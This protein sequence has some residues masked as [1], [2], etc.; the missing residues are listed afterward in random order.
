ME[1]NFRFSGFNWFNAINQCNITIGGVGGIGSYVAFLLARAQALSL[2]L[3]DMDRVETHNLGCQLFFKNS[4]NDLKTKSC[5]AFISETTNLR[6]DIYLN[7]EITPETDKYV[8]CQYTFSCFDNFKA[9]KILFNLW[10]ERLN[11]FSGEDRKKS[12]FIDGR[13]DGELLQIYCVTEDNYLLYEPTLNEENLVTMGT[14]CT[15]QQTSHVGAMIASHMV[16]F[17]TNHLANLEEGIDYREVPY[18]YEVFI[19]LAQVTTI[20]KAESIEKVKALQAVQEPLSF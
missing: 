12:I 7:G 8:I 13:L 3:W 9:R 5:E 10:K 2:N 6:T 14:H 4:L 20:S 1:E 11:T 19:P 15:M 16:S 18:F 17:F